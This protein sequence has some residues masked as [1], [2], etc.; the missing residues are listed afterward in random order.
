MLHKLA[1]QFVLS[2]SS[3]RYKTSRDIKKMRIENK[4]KTMNINFKTQFVTSF[5]ENSVGGEN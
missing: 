1:P 2:S 3:L 4:K 5:S